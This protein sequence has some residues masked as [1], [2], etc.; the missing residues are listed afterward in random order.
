MLKPHQRIEFKKTSLNL[1]PELLATDYE[2][3][4][5]AE[6]V[7][8]LLVTSDDVIHGFAV[9]SFGLKIDAIPG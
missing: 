6:R 4:V 8:R 9:P 3:V 1:Y 7:I 2:L 5:P